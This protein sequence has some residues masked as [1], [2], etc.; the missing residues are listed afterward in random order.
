MHAASLDQ[1]MDQVLERSALNAQLAE[2]K[3]KLGLAQ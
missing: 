1:Q 3:R 2:R